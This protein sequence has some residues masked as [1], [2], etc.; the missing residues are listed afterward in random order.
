MWREGV[1]EMDRNWPGG[2]KRSGAS[3]RARAGGIGH[4][5]DTARR[6][7]VLRTRSGRRVRSDET[8]GLERPS[9]LQNVQWTHAREFY[10]VGW[11]VSAT[12][13]IWTRGR[14]VDRAATLRSR[15]EGAVRRTSVPPRK[16][17]D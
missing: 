17:S 3:A 13:P 1:A 16:A 14:K 6:E 8:A 7:T 15:H 5:E 2:A 9:C 11:R 4:C 12:P 10:R